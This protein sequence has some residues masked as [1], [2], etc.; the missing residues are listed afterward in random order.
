VTA[1]VPPGLE[2]TD[3]PQ[4]HALG[5]SRGGLSTK[6]HLACDGQGRAPAFVLSAGNVNDCT[7]FEQV[8]TAIKVGRGGPD[9]PRVRPDQVIADKGYSSKAI[10]EYLR[11]RGIPHTIPERA[12]Q[13]ANRRRRGPRGGRPPTFDTQ[14]HKRRNVVE[15]C[16]NVPKQC[17]GLATRYDKTSTSY[18]ATVKQKDSYYGVYYRRLAARRGRQRALVAVMYKRRKW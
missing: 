17:R 9:R 2:E 5:R 12:D 1:G 14:L 15:R 18:Q 10:R 11:R 16:F 6:T 3:E 4:D 7:R 13:I 8:M